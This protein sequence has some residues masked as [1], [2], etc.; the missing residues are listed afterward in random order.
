MLVDH[1][2]PGGAVPHTGHGVAK[3]GTGV[4]R[5][6]VAGVAE[7]MEV[8]A[9]QVGRLRGVLPGPAEVAAPELRVLGSGEDQG[10]LAQGR[11]VL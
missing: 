8:E 9:G 7:I 5:Q 10:I 6:R 4:R 1:R 11:E 3:T 2:G